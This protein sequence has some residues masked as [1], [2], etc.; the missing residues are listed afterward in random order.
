[1]IEDKI[2]HVVYEVT[3]S[4]D[5]LSKIENT[6]LLDK[7]IAAAPDDQSKLDLKNKDMHEELNM[8]LD[9]IKVKDKESVIDEFKTLNIN[10]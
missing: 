3:G 7:K 9:Y 6:E 5:E 2:N 8:Y 1:M 10:V 4:I